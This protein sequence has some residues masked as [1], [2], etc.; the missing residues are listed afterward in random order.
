M[1]AEPFV[2]P[3]LAMGMNEGTLQEWLIVEGEFVEQGQEIACMET[4]KVAYELEAPE[5]GYY[6]PIIEA[7][8]TVPVETPIAY[9][10]DSVEAL[11]GISIT[12]PADSAK[13]AAAPP[14]ERLSA[15]VPTTAPPQVTAAIDSGRIKASPLARKLAA[16]KG[17]DLA[18]IEGTGPEGRIVKRDI[19]KAERTGMGCAPV[20]AAGMPAGLVEQARIP[21]SG[22]RHS[23][24]DALMEKSNGTAT[25]TQWNEADVTDLLATRKR[26]VAQEEMLG[27]KVSV[28]AFFIKAIAWAARQVPIINSTLQGDDIVVYDN[29][30]V[31]MALTVPSG[32]SYTENLMVPV[33]R[34]AD[35][36]RLVEIDREMKRLIG[37]GRE[38]R[39]SAADMADSTITFSTTAGIA[40]DGTAGNSILNGSNNAIVGIGGAKLKPAEHNGEIALR[41]I[42]PVLVSY[43]HR[44]IDGAPASRFMNYLH[45]A[46]QDPTLLLA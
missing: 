15:G 14:T 46:L 42:A 45:Q 13:A 12:T 17:L 28:N 43:D 26:M 33:I 37:L 19:E 6:K 27:A 7:G 1:T 24:I 44:V 34:H 16:D 18:Y 29:I 35:R 3:K 5:A 41:H 21:M 40:P 20:A 39:L 32:D 9:Y 30:N 4:E 38:G 23:I 31:A 36:L 22:I 8:T 25:L 2:M 11:A 10:A